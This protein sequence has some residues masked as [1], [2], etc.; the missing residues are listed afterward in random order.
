VGFD[1]ENIK[2]MNWPS[3]EEDPMSTLIL[4]DSDK[5]VIKALAKKY[6][7]NKD[8][9]GADFIR[10]KGEGQIFLLHGKRAYCAYWVPALTVINRTARNWENLYSR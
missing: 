10:G 2:P 8:R 4:G 5:D 9:W 6:S 7:K 1:V 3:K